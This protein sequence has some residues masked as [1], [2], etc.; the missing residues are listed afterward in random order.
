MA[1]A[2]PLWDLAIT[3]FVVLLQ[4]LTTSV[5]LVILSGVLGLIALGARLAF[6]D[7]T[8]HLRRRG[9]GSKFNSV[10][11]MW[12]SVRSVNEQLRK[13]WLQPATVHVID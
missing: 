11:Q 10:S 6:A 12:V 5:P 7:R 3:G 13:G 8:R 2:H 1:L 9:S 4:L